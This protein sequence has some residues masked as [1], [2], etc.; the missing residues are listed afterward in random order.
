MRTVILAALGLVLA[1]CASAEPAG[2]STVTQQSAQATDYTD[3]RSH[4]SDDAVREARR[5]YRAACQQRN[6]DG[7]CECM[8]GGMAQALAPADLAVATAAVSGQS[9]QASAESRARAE[10]ARAEVEPGCAQFR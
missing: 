7:F 2:Q 8:T 9:I 6:S 1:A 3:A 4:A 10:A 5:A